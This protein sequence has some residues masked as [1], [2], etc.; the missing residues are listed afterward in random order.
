V[1]PRGSEMACAQCSTVI[2]SDNKPTSST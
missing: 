1:S 2:A